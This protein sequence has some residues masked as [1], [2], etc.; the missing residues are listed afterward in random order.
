MMSKS[1]LIVPRWRTLPFGEHRSMAEVVETEDLLAR[2]AR[3]EHMSAHGV[4]LYSLLSR[5]VDPQNE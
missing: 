3:G 2:R 5:A 4:R 1:G